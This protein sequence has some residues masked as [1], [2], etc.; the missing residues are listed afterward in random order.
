[1]RLYLMPVFKL[2]FNTRLLFLCLCLHTFFQ[3]LGSHVVFDL[4]EVLN[5]VP[6]F[7]LD[8]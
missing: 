5:P 3:P 6:M 8:P 1:M 2:K 4:L 7:H